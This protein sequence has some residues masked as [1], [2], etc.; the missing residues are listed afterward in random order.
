MQAQL[1]QV[2]LRERESL[3]SLREKTD[4]LQ[5]VLRQTAKQGETEESKREQELKVLEN[6]ANLEVI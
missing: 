5:E 2:T 1:R 6:N 4:K 3:A